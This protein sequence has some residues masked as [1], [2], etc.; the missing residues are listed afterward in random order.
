MRGLDLIAE[1]RASEHPLVG[2]AAKQIG[3]I[4]VTVREL[5]YGQ[6]PGKIWDVIPKKGREAG[7]IEIFPCANGTSFFYSC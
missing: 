2:S 1:R 5:Q 7:Y 6:F 3:E 4:R